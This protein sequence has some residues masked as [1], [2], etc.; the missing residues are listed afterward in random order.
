MSKMKVPFVDLSIQYQLIKEELDVAFSEVFGN[1]QFIGGDPVDA[2]EK[3]FAQYLGVA[4]CISCGNGTDALELA[5]KA[6]DLKAGDEVIV[7][8]NSW[9]STAEAV[10]NIGGRPVFVDVSPL[11]YNLDVNLL[12]EAISSKTRGIIVVHLAGMP[13]QISEILAFADKNGL[14]VL[15]D[16]A[17]AH[18]AS[19]NEKKVGSF[20]HAATFS[21]YPTKNLGAYGDAGAVV[22]SDSF[23][24]ERV[25]RLS[26]HGTLFKHDH[27]FPGRNSNLD[28]I[29]AAFLNVKLKYL[30]SWNHLRNQVANWYHQYLPAGLRVHKVPKGFYYTYHL[31]VVEVQKRDRL[32]VFLEDRGV[33]TG[34]HYP[35]AI[36]YTE[37]YKSFNNSNDSFPVA[38]QLSK[39]CLSL[40]MFP[41]LEEEQVR[42]ICSVINDFYS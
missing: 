42:Y 19:I 33:A 7:P 1:S 32:K 15:E 16:C 10:T 14:F 3:D 39:D 30:D 21:F 5:L 22:T 2:F 37:A 17:Q 18:G 20:G 25:R 29:Q 8:A 4:H 27:L 26:N 31:F 9:I 35:V 36:P 41:E 23:L 40:P 24:A 13:A 38:L 12:S 6:L 28:T 11:T 34:I